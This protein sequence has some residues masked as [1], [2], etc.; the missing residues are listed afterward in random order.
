MAI[1]VNTFAT[2]DRPG[3][4]Y[5]GTCEDHIHLEAGEQAPDCTMCKRPV[6]WFYLRPLVRRAIGFVT[7]S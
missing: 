1:M 3:M 5:C 2:V 6:T 4:Y 7:G